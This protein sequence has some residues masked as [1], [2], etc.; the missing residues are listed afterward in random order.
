MLA[1]LAMEITELG[2]DYIAGRM[3]VDHRTTQTFGILHGG[4]SVA[5]A[6][7][8]GSIGANL[9]VDPTRQFCVGLDINANHLRALREG[10]IYAKAYP[11]HRGR[12]TQVWQ[13]DITNEEGKT[14]TSSRLTMA[15]RDQAPQE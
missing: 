13:I 9:C 1:H 7:S 4:A 15:V 12:T 2:E 6:E 8:L 10:Y 3:P 14:V 11:V 5:L